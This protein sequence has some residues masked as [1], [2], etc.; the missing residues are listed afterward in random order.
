MNIK[1]LLPNFEEQL[2]TV[3]KFTTVISLTNHHFDE[4]LLF[5]NFLFRY[6]FWSG[7]IGISY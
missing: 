3:S 5:S 6:S 2:L 4:L 7:K 1:P